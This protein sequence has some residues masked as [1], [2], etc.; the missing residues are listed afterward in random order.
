MP[1]N[2]G[3]RPQLVVTVPYDVLR[4]ELGTGQ[5]DTGEQL[6]ATQVRQLACD[7]LILPTVLGGD[8]QILDYDRTRRLV[9]APLRRALALRDK[10]CTFPG[11]TRPPRWCH[12]HHIDAW[13]HGG[14][15]CLTNCALL[16]HQH[17]RLIHRKH[18]TMRIAAD[19]H[20][21]FIPPTWLDPNRTPRRNT[22][23]RPR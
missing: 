23:H 20:P 17:H 10:G 19:G 1:V 3:D 4:K 2:G 22:Y 11:C 6:T 13:E 9:P 12:A 14:N 15:T 7:A 8:G 21:E 16:C 18:W 5:L